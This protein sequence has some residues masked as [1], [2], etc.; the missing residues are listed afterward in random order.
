MKKDRESVHLSPEHGLH[1][2]RGD[3]TRSEPG[4]AS[5]NDQANAFVT[6]PAF[7]LASNGF[8]LVGNDCLASK[9]MARRRQAI[10]ASARVVE[11]STDAPATA[12]GSTRPSTSFTRA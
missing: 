3:V 2:F 7:H 5:R 12:S 11:E 8:D 1:R 6:G 10:V 4:S 9:L